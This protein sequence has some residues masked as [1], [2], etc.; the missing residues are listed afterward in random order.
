MYQYLNID[1]NENSRHTRYHEV[2]HRLRIIVYHKTSIDNRTSR[3]NIA[4][5]V[6]RHWARS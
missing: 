1:S 2:A 5:A 4:N 3:L 6:A